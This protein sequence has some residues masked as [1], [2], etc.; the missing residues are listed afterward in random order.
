MDMRLRATVGLLGSGKCG[1][2]MRVDG[3]GNGY[4]LSLDL[5]KGLAQIRAWG[6]NDGREHDRAFNYQQLQAGHFVNT[7]RG[8]WDIEVVAHGMYLEVSING[9]VTISVVDDAYRGGRFGFYAESAALQVTSLRAELLNP[10]SDT[11]EYGPLYTAAMHPED[12][13]PAGPHKDRSP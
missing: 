8:P 12:E 2:V 4:Y 13:L 10:P 5:I 6:E 1:M 3:Q 11:G 9:Y 7:G